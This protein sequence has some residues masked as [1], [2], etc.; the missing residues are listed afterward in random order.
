MDGKQ[1][2]GLILALHYAVGLVE[3]LPQLV[4]DVL[5]SRRPPGRIGCG[6]PLS[7][8]GDLITHGSGLVVRRDR[9]HLLEDDPESKDVRRLGEFA[10]RVLRLRRQICRRPGERVAAPSV[11]HRPRETEVS[12]ERHAGLEQD[13]FRL[14]IPMHQAR[15]L[16]V[17][18][19][20]AVREAP[21]EE[22]DH[23]NGD[24]QTVQEV[25]Q[26]DDT[27][28]ARQESRHSE[29]EHPVDA[30]NVAVDEARQG[31]DLD[32]EHAFPQERPSPYRVEQEVLREGLAG[33]G[34]G[35][36]WAT[37]VF[38]IEAEVDLTVPTT[39]QVE[40][41]KTRT[42]IPDDLYL[43]SHIPE[44]R[45]PS[46]PRLRPRAHED[47]TRGSVTDHDQAPGWLSGKHKARD[48][49]R[50]AAL[51]GRST[52]STASQ[53]CRCEDASRSPPVPL[54]SDPWSLASG[55]LCQVFHAA[56]VSQARVT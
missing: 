46:L 53:R 49:T 10:I 18:H 27:V 32:R 45:Y 40:H 28:L 50:T 20:Q 6:A 15:K 26:I 39:L 9:Q 51:R 35:G 4:R 12:D 2:T 3:H 21:P 34:Q 29:D 44:D 56:R 43:T 37:R 23:G 16:L 11:P 31:G 41:L 52:A 47:L 48:S 30:E 38:F 8:P 13:V 54:P 17:R 1:L 25:S 42:Q 24:R 14:Q 19:C 5:E 55:R 36:I 33:P 7:Q 22:G